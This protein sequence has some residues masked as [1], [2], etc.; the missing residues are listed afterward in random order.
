MMSNK[1][2]IGNFNFQ[3]LIENV[4]PNDP[5]RVSFLEFACSR[6]AGWF[7]NFA[8]SGLSGLGW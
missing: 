7:L 3:T 6:L 2:K 1:F 8:I 5:V 4:Q